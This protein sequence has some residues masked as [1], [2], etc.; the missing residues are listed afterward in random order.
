M[1][2]SSYVCYARGDVHGIWSYGY[3]NYFLY[4]FEVSCNVISFFVAVYEWFKANQY[5]IWCKHFLAHE[6]WVAHRVTCLSLVISNIR[7]H[8]ERE[9]ISQWKPEQRQA[10]NIPSLNVNYSLPFISICKRGNMHNGFK[11]KWRFSLIL[12]V[13]QSH[14]C[15][16]L[17]TAQSI[18]CNC[19]CE[20]E[21]DCVC[22]TCLCA[23]SL[24]TLYKR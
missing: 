8:Y 2:L 4:L 5:A 13:S 11:P 16:V 9:S 3:L 1:C 15:T 14:V 7:V 20:C 23:F 21:F 12:Y 6:N 18:Y 24:C 17:R 19:W 22:A 10:L